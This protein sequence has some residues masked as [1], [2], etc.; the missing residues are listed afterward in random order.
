MATFPLIDAGQLAENAGANTA[1]SRGTSI[2][3]NATANTKGNFTELIASTSFDATSLLV[4]LDDISSA[5]DYLID[6]AI[7]GAGSE[8]VVISNLIVTGGTGSIVYGGHYLLPVNI[9]AG[10]RV[11]ARC[12][13]S[14]G[15]AVVRVSAQLFG[16]GMGGAETLGL[17]A[18][19]GDNTATSGGTQVD[20]GG[21][22]NTK[23]SYVQIA[24]STT[25]P[26]RFLVIA[27][28]NKLNNIRSSQSW[29]MDVAIGGAGSETV[30][31][32]NM[33]FNCSTSPDI[34]TPQTYCMIPVNIP[35]GTRIAVRAQSDG[36][37]ATDRLFDVIL[38]GAG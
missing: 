14:T 27:I 36:I 12:Q 10:S 31:L 20:P 11:S 6:I 33:A 1:L 13:A 32:S 9:P 22:A 3:A 15:S 37:D 2:T 23:G 5:T 16:S 26:I 17:V 29:L 18:T 38:Y 35:A 25:Y 24:A 8:V 28:G 21:T 19:Y 34:I 4:M 7:G 30:I